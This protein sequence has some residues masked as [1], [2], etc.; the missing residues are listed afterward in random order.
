M[1]NERPETPRVNAKPSDRDILAF[2]AM[3]EN[4]FQMLILG[5]C[6]LPI[7]NAVLA[8]FTGNSGDL[9]IVDKTSSKATKSERVRDPIKRVEKQ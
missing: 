5:K 4:D 2:S 3:Q 1:I 7:D 8:T 9:Q 6:A